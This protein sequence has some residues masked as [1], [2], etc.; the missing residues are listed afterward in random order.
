MKT[1]RAL[2]RPR[3]AR[4]VESLLALDLGFGR[5]VALEIKAANMLADVV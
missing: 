1:L 5:I 2:N 3:R 4:T